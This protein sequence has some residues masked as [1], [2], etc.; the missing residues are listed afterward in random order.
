MT[1]EKTAPSF[2]MEYRFV[3]AGDRVLG[4]IMSR[5]LPQ[6]QAFVGGTADK[7][8]ALITMCCGS[9]VGTGTIIERI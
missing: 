2:R 9:S 1:R 5:R 6:S 3:H 4:G 8:T 7:S